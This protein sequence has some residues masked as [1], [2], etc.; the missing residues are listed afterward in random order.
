MDNRCSEDLKAA[1]SK[2]ELAF[3]LVPPH[4]HKSNKAAR[5]IP[6]FKGHLKSSLASLDPN[7]PIHKW[8]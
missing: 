3:Q 4:I 8:D 2:A 5:A 6:T 7:F 1:L